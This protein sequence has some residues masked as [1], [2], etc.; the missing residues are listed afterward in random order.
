[1]TI[2]NPAILVLPRIERCFAS[3]KPVA[4]VVENMLLGIPIIEGAGHR[5]RKR[6]GILE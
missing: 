2:H 3:P 1:M 6:S 4:V 5:H